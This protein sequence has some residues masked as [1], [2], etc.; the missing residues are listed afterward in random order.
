MVNSV[1]T[2]YTFC[3]KI[4]R[5]AGEVEA[6]I[7]EIRRLSQTLESI[8]QIVGDRGTQK[9][10]VRTSSLISKL[11]EAIAR[12][13]ADLETWTSSLAALGMEDGKWAK[14][15]VKRLKLAAD[16]GRFSETRLK[17]SSHRDQLALLVDLLTVDLELSTSLNVQAIHYKIDNL[18]VEHASSQ[19]INAHHLEK[20]QQE[21]QNVGA[22]Q[23]TTLETTLGIS[24][25]TDKIHDTVQDIQ[26]SQVTSHQTTRRQFE[27]LDARLAAMQHSLLNIPIAHQKGIRTRRRVRRPD[28]RRHVSQGGHSVLGIYPELEQ[29][30]S[31]SSAI[32]AQLNRV[33]DI[34]VTARYRCG[35]WHLEALAIPDSAFEAADIGTRLRMVKYLQDLR[36]LLWLLCRKECV[37]DGLLNPSGLPRSRLIAE[38]QLFSHSDLATLFDIP[39]PVYPENIRYNRNLDIWYYRA[40]TSESI[41]GITHR[42]IRTSEDPQAT[43]NAT[44]L[45]TTTVDLLLGITKWLDAKLEQIRH[46]ENLMM[47]CQLSRQIFRMVHELIRLKIQTKTM[48][49]V[50]QALF[51]EACVNE[52]KRRHSKLRGTV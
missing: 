52:R 10:S 40:V 7:D 46:M 31:D 29:R 39:P 51:E 14:N 13:T 23:H 27:C 1:S 47:R 2:L 38:A 21:V 36:L 12:C 35:K 49:I 9:A 48:K 8:Q 50:R 15:S 17:I 44:Q 43:A 22:V 45:I 34:A 19:N 25:S 16:A 3:R 24:R 6:I 4:P 26:M 33:V 30:I 32:T 42:D 28:P 37:W 18:V 11:Q 5:V 41:Y 20:I